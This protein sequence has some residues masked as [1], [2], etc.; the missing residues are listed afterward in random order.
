MRDVENSVQRGSP[1]FR[2]PARGPPVFLR[3]LIRHKRKCQ[4]GTGNQIRDAERGTREILTWMLSVNG[5]SRVMPTALYRTAICV[6]AVTTFPLGAP[7][8][9][10]GN[11]VWKSGLAFAYFSLNRVCVAARSSSHPGVPSPPT[12]KQYG[13]AHSLSVTPSCLYHSLNLCATSR[14]A[15]SAAAP[16][17]ALL[18]AVHPFFCAS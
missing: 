14:I 13:S 15:S 16:S 17:F 7:P 5:I 2:A 11:T 1:E 18:R 12:I 3:E 6:F 9:S 4:S 10:K 8:Y